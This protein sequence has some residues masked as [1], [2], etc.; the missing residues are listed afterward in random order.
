MFILSDRKNKLH[1]Q[2]P[3]PHY[4][5]HCRCHCPHRN[6]T[7]WGQQRRLLVRPWPQPDPPLRSLGLPHTLH[8]E[9]STS[10]AWKGSADINECSQLSSGFVGV[11]CLWHVMTCCNS[12]FAAL[13]QK[14]FRIGTKKNRISTS[15]YLRLRKCNKLR[16]KLRYAAL[17]QLAMGKISCIPYAPSC[18]LWQV[19]GARSLVAVASSALPRVTWQVFGRNNA[20]FCT[21]G[22]HRLQQ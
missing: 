10:G 2:Y 19:S 17:N 3:A 7:A 4:C 20:M 16:G 18:N 21:I 15:W 6:Q 13:S 22:C 11:M 9:R 12:S 8:E 14:T 5:C 1:I